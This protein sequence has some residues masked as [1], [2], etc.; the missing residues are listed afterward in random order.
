MNTIVWIYCAR[1]LLNHQVLES[2]AFYGW[3]NS[4]QLQ[5][6]DLKRAMRISPSCE[7]SKVSLIKCAVARV[8]IVETLTF[9]ALISFNHL[10]S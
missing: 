1:V 5:K 10:V 9:R 8:G 6:T 2:Q 4:Q 7:N 3:P